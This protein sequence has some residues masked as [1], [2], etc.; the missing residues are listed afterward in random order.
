M[1]RTLESESQQTSPKARHRFGFSGIHKRPASST[2]KKSTVVSSD[3]ILD[4]LTRQASS[5]GRLS[6]EQTQVLE[7]LNETDDNFSEEPISSSLT[8]FGRR[9]GKGL[10]YYTIFMM[11]IAGM[12]AVWIYSSGRS[13]FNSTVIT[14]LIQRTNVRSVFANPL[15]IGVILLFSLAIASWIALR[16]KSSHVKLTV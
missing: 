10:G 14:N 16:R 9:R 7:I 1:G 8:T 3:D 15:D 13:V 2:N 4:S 6:E 5:Q 11:G 12:I